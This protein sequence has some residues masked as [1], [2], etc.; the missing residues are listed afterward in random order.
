MAKLGGKI[1]SMTKN[2]ASSF[3]ATVRGTRTAIKHSKAVTKLINNA[4]KLKRSKTVMSH[5]SSRPYTNSTLTIKNIMKAGKPMADSSLKNGLKWVVNGT[6]NGSSGV[7]ELVVD[8][9]TNT[10]VHFLFRSKQ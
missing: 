8:T 6:Y 7:W 4:S 3:K 5:L 10:I 2:V 1:V 9:T